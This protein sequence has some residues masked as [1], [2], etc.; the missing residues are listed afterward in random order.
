L[1]IDPIF[2]SEVC[3]REK[4]QQGFVVVLSVVSSQLSVVTLIWIYRFFLTPDSCLL[5][6]ARRFH[7]P[8]I[9]RRFIRQ[10]LHRHVTNDFAVVRHAHTAVVLNVAMTTASR[11]HF[12]KISTT[13]F[14]RPLCATSSMRSC[15]SESS[16]SYAVMPVSRCGT[17]DR[18]IS[19]PLSPRAA[20]SHVEQVRPAAP[21]S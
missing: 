10:S 9:N 11:S 17:S 7:R 3:G 18:S 12:A 1:P 5:T 15:D 14:E 16:I 20:I 8:L 13:S 2:G 19:M 4:F 6:P 21:I